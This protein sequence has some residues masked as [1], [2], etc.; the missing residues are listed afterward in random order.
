MG[1]GAELEEQLVAQEFR[2]G[3]GAEVVSPAGRLNGKIK[4]I[5]SIFFGSG[6]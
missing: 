6:S 4:P 5:L 3:D 2:V 1:H